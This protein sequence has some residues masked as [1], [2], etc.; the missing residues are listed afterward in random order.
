MISPEQLVNMI[1]H[2]LD[3]PPN[4]YFA[5]GYGADVRAMLLKDPTTNNADKFLA[6]LREDMPLFANF[7]DDRLSIE[8]QTQ[9]FD[10]LKVYLF[11]GNIPVLLGD[12]INQHSFGQDYYDSRAS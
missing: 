3:T 4:G 8:I 7:N 2:W 6:K 10:K 12:S 11:I 5:Q 9:E 1:N